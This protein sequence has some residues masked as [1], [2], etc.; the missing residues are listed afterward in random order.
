[1][2]KPFTIEEFISV[3]SSDLDENFLENNM[4]DDFSEYSPNDDTVKRVLAYSRVLV[5]FQTQ[6]AGSVSL[7]IN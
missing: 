3:A 4:I 6:N 5:V 1:M 2:N 7:I